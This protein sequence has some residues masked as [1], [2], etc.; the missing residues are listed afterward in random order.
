MDALQ[1]AAAELG[2]PCSTQAAALEA[3]YLSSLKEQRGVAATRFAD[4]SGQAKKPLPSGWQNLPHGQG[5]VG[6]PLGGCHGGRRGSTAD[7]PPPA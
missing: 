4:A 2:V 1:W 5:F 7:S 3:R 6:K